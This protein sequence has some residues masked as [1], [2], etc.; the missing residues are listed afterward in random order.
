MRPMGKATLNLRIDDSLK[1]RAA[2]AAQADHRSLTSLVEKLLDDYAREFEADHVS[3][4]RDGPPPEAFKPYIERLSQDAEKF[5]AANV[6]KR[7]AAERRK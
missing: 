1:K 6:P 2:K 7:K 3:M 5:I 4:S